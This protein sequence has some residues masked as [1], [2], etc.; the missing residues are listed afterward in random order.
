[1]AH[2]THH[3][4][5][6]GTEIK[7][8]TAMSASFWFVLIL[9][10][11]FIAAVNFVNVESNTKEEGEGVKTEEVHGA[12]S[13]TPAAEHAT[14]EHAAPAEGAATTE[15]AHQTADTAHAASH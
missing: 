13:E 3:E 1:M 8:K 9:A 10:G 6:H 7:S 14:E 15:A 5:S 12:T 2:E 11:L 4:S